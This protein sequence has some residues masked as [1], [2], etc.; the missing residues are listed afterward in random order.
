MVD[1][2]KYTI[3]RQRPHFMD[4]CRPNIGYTECKDPDV[5]ITN[6]TCTGSNKYLIHESQL[7]FYSGHSAF[8]FYGAWFTS[9]YLQARLYRPLFSRLLLPVIQFSLFGGASYVAL[10]RVSDYKHHWSDVLVGALIGSTIG[11]FVALYVAE[12]FKRREIPACL[13]SND[14]GLIRMEKRSDVNPAVTTATHSFTVT[15][16][17]DPASNQRL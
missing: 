1:I 11:I 3:G 15:N 5:Y 6:F 8:S 10:T 14:F 7:S 2:A 4:V 13:P 16:E 9:L 12:V 17:Q